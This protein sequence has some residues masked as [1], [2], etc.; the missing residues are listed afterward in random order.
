MTSIAPITGDGATIRRRSSGVRVNSL[1]A[2]T[3]CYTAG[4]RAGLEE[5]LRKMDEPKFRGTT[6]N[7]YVFHLARFKDWL[8][9]AARREARE[10]GG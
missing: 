10:G 4:Q 7:R 8:R 9:A 2:M 1:A 5:V 3:D 6:A